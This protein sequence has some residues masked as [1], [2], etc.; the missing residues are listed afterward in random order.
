MNKEVIN[1]NISRNVNEGI[2]KNVEIN[3]FGTESLTEAHMINPDDV[4][5]ESM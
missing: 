4:D 5:E 1:T 2:N 3:K